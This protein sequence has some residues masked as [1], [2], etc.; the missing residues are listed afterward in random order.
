MDDDR[1]HFHCF[2]YPCAGALCVLLLLGGSGTDA[3]NVTLCWGER[4]HLCGV[5]LH[6]PAQTSFGVLGGQPHGH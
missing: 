6:L 4:G 5:G 1:K 3:K 2:F